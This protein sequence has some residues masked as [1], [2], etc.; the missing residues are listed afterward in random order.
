M[1]TFSYYDGGLTTNAAGTAVT[2]P[3]TYPNVLKQYNWLAE[4]AYYNHSSRFSIF[5]KFEGR[6]ISGDYPGPVQAGSNQYW[7]AAGLKMIRKLVRGLHLPAEVALRETK[8]APA[9]R[10]A[11]RGGNQR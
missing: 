9:R 1:A 2:N 10:T 5:G 8:A 11:S 4:A 3:G 7:L 6:K